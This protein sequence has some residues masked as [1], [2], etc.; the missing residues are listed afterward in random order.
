MES[1]VSAP[2]F[3]GFDDETVLVL[4]LDTKADR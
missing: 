1:A 2:R 4:G 3:L